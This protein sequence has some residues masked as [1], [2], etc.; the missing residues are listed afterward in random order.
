MICLFPD[1]VSWQLLTY[2]MYA[3]R[4]ENTDSV[5]HFFY[6]ELIRTT[7]RGVSEQGFEADVLECVSVL[8]DRVC[9]GL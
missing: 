8:R 6:I 5:C 7:D 2:R 9:F 4:K 1:D 3:L